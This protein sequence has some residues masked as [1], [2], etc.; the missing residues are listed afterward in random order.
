MADDSVD[1]EDY[2]N[3]FGDFSD[4]GDDFWNIHFW[5]ILDFMIVTLNFDK[6]LMKLLWKISSPQWRPAVIS[7]PDKKGTL[8]TN[9][10]STN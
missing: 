3:L 2:E 10:F 1:E 7:N 9:G 6:I 5:N 8:E 4:N